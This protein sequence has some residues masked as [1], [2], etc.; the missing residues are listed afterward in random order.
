VR[1]GALV[2]V[3]W[4]AAFDATLRRYFAIGYAEAGADEAILLRYVDLPGEQAAMEFAADHEL[5][6]LDWWSWGRVDR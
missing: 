6:R 3:A 2:D 5:E 4:L 1:G